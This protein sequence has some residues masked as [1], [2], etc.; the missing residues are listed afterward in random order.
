M[1]NCIFLFIIRHSFIVVSD[2]RYVTVALALQYTYPLVH[3]GLVCEQFVDSLRE[4]DVLAVNLMLCCNEAVVD[5]LSIV[6]YEHRREE[7]VKPVPV[8]EV[9]GVAPQSDD[10]PSPEH[11]EFFPADTITVPST[12]Q[13]AEFSAMAEQYQVIGTGPEKFFDLMPAW[14]HKHVGVKSLGQVGVPPSVWSAV[15][16]NSVNHNISVLGYNGKRTVLLHS[17]S[18]FNQVVLIT[19][20]IAACSVL[21]V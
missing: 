10:T 2:K 17:P 6:G 4:Y 11:L 18:D 15:H 5:S 3:R 7:T 8:G 14:V 16:N 20:I 12:V 13:K 21:C 9:A 19:V 1:L